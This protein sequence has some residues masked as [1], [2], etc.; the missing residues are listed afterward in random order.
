MLVEVPEVVDIHITRLVG[1]IHTITKR[2][3]T[4]VLSLVSK[5]VSTIRLNVR[6]AWGNG[7]ILMLIDGKE[8]TSV[9]LTS[10]LP[11]E[12]SVGTWFGTL[13]G[14]LVD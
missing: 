5:P 2:V 9:V 1:K 13:V 7:N 14:S 6:K 12:S 8:F 3:S 4:S 11:S 10:V